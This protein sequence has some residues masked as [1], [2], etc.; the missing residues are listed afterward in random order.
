[1]R[2]NEADE[3]LAAVESAD[4]SDSAAEEGGELL[5]RVLVPRPQ[6][7]GELVAEASDRDEDRGEAVDPEVGEANAL[8]AAVVVN[9]D[10]HVDVDR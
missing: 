1:M 7:V 8:L 10:G 9:H 5:L 2:G 4:E 3:D 6:F